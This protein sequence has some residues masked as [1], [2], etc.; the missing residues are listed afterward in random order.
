MV[1][2]DSTE[3]VIKYVNSNGQL[4]TGVSVVATGDGALYITSDPEGFI[5]NY[6]LVT[7]V[8]AVSAWFHGLV[9]MFMLKA[10]V[11]QT[12]HIDESVS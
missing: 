5:A 3:I 11:S 1:A 12:L 2:P 6:S 9:C 4:A 8:I 10:F 7:P